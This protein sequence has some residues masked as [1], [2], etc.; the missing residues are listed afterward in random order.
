MSEQHTLSRRTVGRITA[1]AA[2]A[3]AVLLGSAVGAFSIEGS[4]GDHPVPSET[5]AVDLP[6]PTTD[7][8]TSIEATLSTRRSRRTFTDEPLSNSDLGQLLWAAQGITEPHPDGVDFRTA[9]SAGATYPLEVF[10][11]VGTPGVEGIAQG[12]YYHQRHEH[13]LVMRREGEFL[14]PLQQA[15]L[16][17]EWI[18]DAAVT[19]VVTAVDSRTTDRYGQRGRERYVPMEAGH[20]GQ[21]LYLQAEGRG[22][23]TV[24]IGAFRD[25]EVRDVLGVADDHRPLSLFPVGKRR[26]GT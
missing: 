25:R 2:T 8:E 18:G 9:P 22:L 16:G 20:V 17:Q 23:A 7:G 5:T 13:R 19:L 12:V 10:V 3:G 4:D 11:V 14:A 6:P 15:G 1:A 21:N 26:E 24:S